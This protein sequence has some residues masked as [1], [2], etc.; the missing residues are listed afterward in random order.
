MYVAY[1]TL[2]AEVYANAC[3]F[4][5]GC[6]EDL[7]VVNLSHVNKNECGKLPLVALVL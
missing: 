6:W 1:G 7:K 5:L 2:S 3:N 4:C